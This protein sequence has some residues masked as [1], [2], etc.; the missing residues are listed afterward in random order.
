MS[1]HLHAQRVWVGSLAAIGAAAAMLGFSC[2]MPEWNESRLASVSGQL[3]YHGHPVRG[4]KI[5]LDV[6]KLHC[7]AGVL[8]PDGSF[9]ITNSGRLSGVVPARYRVHFECTTNGSQLPDKY[10][11]ADTSDLEFDLLPGWNQFSIELL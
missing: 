9:E 11:E 6:G 10:T 8:R 3:T 7:A 5:C 4:V 2:E 1:S